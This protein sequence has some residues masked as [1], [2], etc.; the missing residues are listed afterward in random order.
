MN[1][2]EKQELI[3]SLKQQLSGMEF[4]A[5]VK[6]K[7]LTVSDVTDLRRKVNALG[8]S[9]YRVAKN[10]LSRLA[11]QGTSMEPLLNSLSGPTALAYGNSYVELAKV[12]VE[13]SKTNDK[14]ALLA[15]FLNG[16]L[17]S[18]K[19]LV[20]LSKMPTLTELRAQIVSFLRA[21]AMEIHRLLKLMS[22][23]GSASAEGNDVVVQEEQGIEKQEQAQTQT[24]GE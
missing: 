2:A 23:G 11:I 15:G 3:S 22:E 14:L 8:D 17:L 4:V 5:V 20:S 24:E 7:G 1:R 18:D 19:E 16:K 9:G 10:T 21:P 13:F 12:L 6:N